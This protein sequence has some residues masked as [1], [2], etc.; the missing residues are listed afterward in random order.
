MNIDKNLVF[1][2]IL[3]FLV[4]YIQKMLFSFNIDINLFL[5]L[6]VI[7]I[8]T[9][10]KSQI[11]LILLFFIYTLFIISNYF[12]GLIFLLIVLWLC[13]ALTVLKKYTNFSIIFKFIIILLIVALWHL[14]FWILFRSTQ[15]KT[16]VTYSIVETIIILAVVSLV[17]SRQKKLI[18]V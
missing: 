2:A 15:W 17:D 13:V 14:S 12:S 4:G 18:I 1:V 9:D 11:Q 8:I 5:I 10:N 3:G 6:G 16:S 7:Y